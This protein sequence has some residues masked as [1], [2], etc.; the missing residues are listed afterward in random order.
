[1]RW[2]GM[3]VLQKNF[4]NIPFHG[5]TELA[6]EVI[7]SVCTVKVN[8]RKFGPLP[9]CGNGLIFLKGLLHMVGV[10]FTHV[11]NNKVVGDETENN[12]APFVAP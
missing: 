10:A 8:Y 12:W 2:F 7:A 9:I 5:Q 4:G 1:M 11:F 6:M 3:S